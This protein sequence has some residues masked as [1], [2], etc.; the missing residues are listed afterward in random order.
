MTDKQTRRQHRH[1]ATAADGAVEVRATEHEQRGGLEAA[2]AL[3]VPGLGIGLLEHPLVDSVDRDPA[4]VALGLD[5]KD[6]TRSDE[7]VID[8]A[9][10]AVDVVD[11][12]QPLACSASRIAPTVSSPRAP[13]AQRS[14]RGN[15]CRSSS[16][17]PAAVPSSASTTARASKPAAATIVTPSRPSA[18]IARI[19]RRPSLWLV[20]RVC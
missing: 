14:T 4:A 18:A 12:R 20:C 8:V 13:R 7:K 10:A 2:D 11:G 15:S 5:G 9:A 19:S 6:A 1:A 3:D 17:T 16:T